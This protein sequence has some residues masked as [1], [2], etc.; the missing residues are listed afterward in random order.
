MA[1]RPTQA[2]PDREPGGTPMSSADA[3]AQY[4]RRC[5]D[6]PVLTHAELRVEVQL[7]GLRY[8]DLAEPFWLALFRR[9]DHRHL[10]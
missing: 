2:V 8:E 1:T 5:G 7:A 9:P 3:Y 4:R 10:N 6:S